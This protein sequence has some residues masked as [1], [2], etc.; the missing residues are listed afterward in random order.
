VTLD[1]V[2]DPLRIIVGIVLHFHLEKQI[3]AAHPSLAPLLNMRF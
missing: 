1:F 2:A 3:R